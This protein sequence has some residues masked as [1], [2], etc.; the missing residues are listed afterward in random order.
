[1]GARSFSQSI[2]YSGGQ[3]SVGQGGF[4]GSG[5]ARCKKEGFDHQEG[6]VASVEAIQSLTE[7]MDQAHALLE[8][9]N[10]ADPLSEKVIENK[11]MLRK[12]MTAS[13]TVDFIEALEMGGEPVWGLTQKERS[14][15]KEAREMMS[16]S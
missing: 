5:G 7:I 10:G 11:A 15:V 9:I 8:T 16:N 12:L 2:T 1:M 14:L 4:Y 13:T 6:A 3:A